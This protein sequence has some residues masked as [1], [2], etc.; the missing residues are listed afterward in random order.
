M[1]NR[2]IE[3]LAVNAV[4]TSIACTD[5][6]APFFSRDDTKPSWDGFILVYKNGT[7]IKKNLDGEVP[8]QIKGTVNN[9]FPNKITFPVEIADL[10]NYRNNGAIYFVVR[11]NKNNNDRGKIYYE[12]LTPVKI[13][14]YLK[15]AK[16]QKTKTIELKEFPADKI[17]KTA[18]VLNFLKNS[19]KQTSYVESGFISADEI[20]KN[21]HQHNLSFS[22][23]GYGSNTRDSIFSTIL[24]SELYAYV[25]TEATK[26]LVPVDTPFTAKEIRGIGD[27]SVSIG[28]TCYYDSYI[29]I[30]SEKGTTIK[31]GES[32]RLEFGNFDTTTLKANICFSKYLRKAAKDMQFVIDAMT[33]KQLNIA[34]FKLKLDS[35]DFPDFISTTQ[36]QLTFYNKI[37]DML[38]ILNVSE[39]LNT[40][41]L[42]IEEKRN[43]ETLIKIFVDKEEITNI[44]KDTPMSILDLKISNINLK[45]IIREKENGAH[46]IEDFFYSE[47]VALYKDENGDH[48]ITPPYSALSKDDYLIVSNINYEKILESYK[49]IAIENPNIFYRANYDLLQMLLAFDE[50]PK[51]ELLNT[52]KELAYWI[53]TEGKD[54]NKNIRVLNYLQIIKRERPLVKDENRQLCE[55]AEAISSSEEEKTGAYLL[56]DSQMS[57]EMHFEKLNQ[58]EQKDFRLYPIYNKFWKHSEYN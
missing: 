39:D 35:I 29:W 18:I 58:E 10:N 2:Q 34:T 11:I 49:K 37:I 25:S 56:L 44:S 50:K 28:N 1:D 33:A 20:Q 4:E 43:I 19:R 17:D 22:I 30:Y 41:R 13:Q 47:L 52:A 55:I 26:A 51:K 14:K 6:L 9:N 53:L 42:T 23:S 8:V 15:E 48:H 54:I 36:M 40:S 21:R 3:I 57:A 27:G 5:I 7:K 46:T 45:L 32:I 31:I 16:G 38:N 24:K 12:T